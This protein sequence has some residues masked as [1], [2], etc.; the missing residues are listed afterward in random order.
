MESPGKRN[1]SPG[2]HLDLSSPPA[3]AARS[4]ADQ[5]SKRFVGVH[6]ACCHVYTRV[7]IN[8]SETAYTGFC[9][10]CGKRIRLRI[11]PEGTDHRFFTA[12]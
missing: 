12:Y 3:D 1:A 7:Y 10:R 9:P 6:F 4:S 8:R 2:E 5:K 11:G